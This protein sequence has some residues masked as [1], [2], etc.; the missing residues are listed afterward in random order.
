MGLAA[1]AAVTFAA[2]VEVGIVVCGAVR[3]ALAQRRET[4]SHAAAWHRCQLRALPS[5]SSSLCSEAT[6]YSYTFDQVAAGT[7]T[8]QLTAINA[9]NDRSSGPT[10]GSVIVGLPGQPRVQSAVGAVGKATITWQVP[11]SNP[12]TEPGER[13]QQVHLVQERVERREGDTSIG[14]K[15]ACPGLQRQL[16]LYCEYSCAGRARSAC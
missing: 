6:S 3:K 1:S 14:R 5:A 10:P 7:Y 8:F 11:I 2:E 16:H 9:N 13:R 4:Q 15:A 12:S